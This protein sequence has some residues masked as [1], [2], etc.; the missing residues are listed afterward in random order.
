MKNLCQKNY[1]KSKKIKKL[2]FS[3]NDPLFLYENAQ[4]PR[5]KTQKHYLL[6]N[7][8]QMKKIYIRKASTKIVKKLIVDTKRKIFQLGSM[9]LIVG[10]R[11]KRVFAKFRTS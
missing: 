5:S 4:R 6:T 7:N 3:E 9:N 1:Q 8:F 2:L 11:L 10:N